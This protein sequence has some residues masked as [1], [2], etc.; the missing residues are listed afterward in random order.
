MSV[1]INHVTSVTT[2]TR[3]C[4]HIRNGSQMRRLYS[5]RGVYG[6]SVV[7]TGDTGDIRSFVRI[8]ALAIGAFGLPEN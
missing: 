1:K 4:A 5:N 8:D 6:K 2:V 3:M 7:T